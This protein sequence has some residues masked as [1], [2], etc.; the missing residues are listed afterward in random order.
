M[1]DTTAT[2]ASP[3]D[4]IVRSGDPDQDRARIVA[5]VLEVEADRVLVGMPL[6]LSG[7]AG[8]EAEAAS[9]E[10]EALQVALPGVEVLLVDERLTTVSASRGMRERGIKAARQRS[11]ID[12]EAASVLLQAW[13]DRSPA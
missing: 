12:A 11:R 10:R 2:L 9:A 5:L 7:Q 8:P 1:S 13:L 6:R 4:V 3:Y